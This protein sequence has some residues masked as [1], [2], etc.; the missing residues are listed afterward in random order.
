MTENISQIASSLQLPVEPYEPHLEQ[1]IASSSEQEI[2]VIR[3][4]SPK[5]IE[6]P[7]EISY[8]NAENVE[9]SFFVFNKKNAGEEV[10][11]LYLL[12]LYLLLLH[13][14]SIVIPI[15]CKLIFF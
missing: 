4:T 14:E 3:S 10:L 1:T 8:E 11:F 7:D 13:G 12:Y 15:F 6:E 2:N 5:A 9:D